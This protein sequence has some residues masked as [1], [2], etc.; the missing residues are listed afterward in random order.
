MYPDRSRGAGYLG[1]RLAGDLGRESGE[2]CADRRRVGRDPG[3]DLL[4]FSTQKIKST[5]TVIHSLKSIIAATRNTNVYQRFSI[6]QGR[7]PGRDLLKITPEFQHERERESE[8]ESGRQ[9]RTCKVPRERG[10][11]Q[12]GPQR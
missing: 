11:G 9:V 1:R 4:K 6:T 8:Q 10:A 12:G 5:A 7:D 2:R 3:R